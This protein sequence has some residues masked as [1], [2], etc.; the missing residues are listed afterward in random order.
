MIFSHLRLVGSAC[1]ASSKA[2]SEQNGSLV[3]LARKCSRNQAAVD[4]WPTRTPNQ[5]P[6][7]PQNF[8][9]PCDS[10]HRL[11]APL[12]RIERTGAVQGS[13]MTHEEAQRLA[14]AAG[15]LEPQ[16]MGERMAAGINKQRDW[17]FQWSQTPVAQQRLALWSQAILNGVAPS[18]LRQEVG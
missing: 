4:Q 5:I 6:T 8:V 15:A 14:I 2:Q 13:R 12:S 9:L 3:Y 1:S 17:S 16:G 7:L 18:D 11:K 10:T